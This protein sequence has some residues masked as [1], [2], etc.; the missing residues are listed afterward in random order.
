M[1]NLK[2][3]LFK[4]LAVGAILILL[5]TTAGLLYAQ[6]MVENKQTAVTHSNPVQKLTSTFTEP[7]V[8]QPQPIRLIFT[9]DVMLD[10]HIRTNAELNGYHSLLDDNLR[11]LLLTANSVVINLEGPITTN[12][13]VSVNSAVGSSNNYI[14]TFDPQVTEFLQA[15]NMNLV[16]LGNNHI[17]NFGEAGLTSTYQYLEDAGI[18][19]FGNTGPAATDSQRVAIIEYEDLTLGF[20]NYNQFV[21]AGLES[22]LAD[23]A[24]LKTKVDLVFV[25][26]HWGN[27]YV[28]ENEVL[29]NQAHQFVDAGADMVIGSHPHVVTGTEDYQNKR[30]YYSLGNFIFDQYFEPAVREGM[31][32]EVVIDPI[33]MSLQFQE[34]MVDMT[35]DG[36]TSLRIE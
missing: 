35:K 6:F 11:S 21:A 12:K 25:Y 27:E 29:I 20:V 16:N 2:N 9:G 28:P 5:L 23:L 33:T 1:L 19:Y 24:D 36:K 14:F 31:I 4:F 34:H 15:N 30:I 18:A 13:S 22:A 7:V 10:R 3:T 8:A 26:T 32:L 17:L